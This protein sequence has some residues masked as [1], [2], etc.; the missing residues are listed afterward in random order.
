MTPYEQC[1]SKSGF[2]VIRARMAFAACSSSCDLRRVGSSEARRVLNETVVLPN[3]AYESNKTIGK[4][5]QGRVG[6]EVTNLAVFEERDGEN[7]FAP[8]PVPED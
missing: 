8:P 2:A 5:G 3:V 6:G 4:D 7:V 1:L